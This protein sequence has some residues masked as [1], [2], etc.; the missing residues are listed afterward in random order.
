MHLNSFDL[1]PDIVTQVF[2]HLMFLVGSPLN[3]LKYFSMQ[4]LGNLCIRHYNFMLE[5]ELKNVYQ[6]LLSESTIEERLKVQALNNIQLYLTEEELRM[7]KQDQEWNKIG[8]LEN[9]KEMGDV[10]SGMASTIVQIYLKQILEAFLNSAIGVRLAA[11]RVI[12]LV[13]QQGLV[14][15]IQVSLSTDICSVFVPKQYFMA[16]VFD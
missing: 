13:L 10:T 4:A 5:S 15:P 16:S 3:D 6:Q 1:Q 14:H 9:I 8:K 12:Q 2:N 7:I 11:V